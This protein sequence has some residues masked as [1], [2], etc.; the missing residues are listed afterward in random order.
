M[1]LISFSIWELFSR[2]DWISISASFEQWL[3]CMRVILRKCFYLTFQYQLHIL[4]AFFYTD[5]GLYTRNSCFYNLLRH[6]WYF[7]FTTSF[8]QFW[9]K[10]DLTLILTCSIYML[11]GIFIPFA[12][13]YVYRII[14]G[15]INISPNELLLQY[16]AKVLRVNFDKFRWIS[17]NIGENQWYFE[18]NESSSKFRRN[19]EALLSWHVRYFAWLCET[20]REISKDIPFG[21]TNFQAKFHWVFWNFVCV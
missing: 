4:T 11:A 20:S 17:T 10:N 14:Q 7:V 8:C 1:S 3:A 21:E 2:T 9:K 5:E 6:F 12:M 16:W 15:Y 19:F 13:C 18:G